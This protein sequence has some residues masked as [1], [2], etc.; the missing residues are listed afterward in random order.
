MKLRWEKSCGGSW[1]AYSGKMLIGLVVERDDGTVGYKIDNISMRW[2]GK[3]FG[4]VSSISSGKRAIERGWRRW[5]TA[6]GLV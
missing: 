5:L 3:A 4:D 1:V 2:V 6:A